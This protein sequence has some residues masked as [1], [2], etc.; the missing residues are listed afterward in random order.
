MIAA[1]GLR[2]ITYERTATPPQ[3]P[4]AC[5]NEARHDAA[6]GGRTLLEIRGA[7]GSWLLAG[8]SGLTVCTCATH[9]DPDHPATSP[10]WPYARIESIT[11]DRYGSLAFL[12]LVLRDHQGILPMIA[13][14]EDQ[15]ATASAGSERLADL[16]RIS[17]AHGTS[18]THVGAAA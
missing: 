15:V 2:A 8:R 1:G 13:F 18:A 16:V 5:R 11:Q 7:L 9:P 10:V 3:P 6:I 4:H 17:Q 14:E 12:G